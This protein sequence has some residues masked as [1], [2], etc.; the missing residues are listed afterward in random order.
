MKRVLPLRAG[1]LQ[2]ASWLAGAG[3]LCLPFAGHAQ[4]QADGLGSS[5]EYI[6]AF[7]RYVHWQDE[8]R[9]DA[10]SVCIVG[11]LPPEQ[12]RAYADRLVRGKS[13]KVRRIDADTPLADCQVLDLTAAD[14]ATT[15]KLLA[16]SRRLPILAIGSGAGFC[17][18]GGQICLHLGER[19]ALDRQKFEV[20]IS[21]MR[22]AT[23]GVSARLLTLG[24]VHTADKDVP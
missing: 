21:A 18:A 23:L 1:V 10:W 11:D 19:S 24:S 17:S 20:N 4:T 5:A 15:A 22:D 9:L 13:F 12:D 7:V 16:R 8:E 14:A 3:L 6:A 2:I